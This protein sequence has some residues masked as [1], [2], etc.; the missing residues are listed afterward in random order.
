MAKVMSGKRR[1][2][3]GV[4]VNDADYVIGKK[5]GGRMDQCPIYNAWQAMLARCYSAKCQDRHPTYRGVTVH[6]EWHRFSSFKR[7]YDE[8]YV[9]GWYLDKDL[10]TDTREYGPN[11][12]IFVPGWLNK[13]TNDSR[14]HRGEWKIGVSWRNDANAFV[15]KCSNPTTKKQ[16]CLGYF[17]SDE[18]AHRAWLD[19]KV[20]LAYQLKD[21]M[22]AIDRRI[23]F[24]VVEIIFRA[25]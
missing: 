16:E 25:K 11:N 15:A 20:E 17:K 12:C 22:D 3:C 7:W 4:G 13:F 23:Y 24:R 21:W 18:E 1:L 8:N 9:E 5:I 2:V 14:A 10:L 19:R 6:E